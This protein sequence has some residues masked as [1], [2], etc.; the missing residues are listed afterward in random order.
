VPAL[1]APPPEFLAAADLLAARAPDSAWRREARPEQLPP[2]GDWFVWLV[3]AGRGWGKTWLGAR[4]LAEQAQANPG[5]YAVIGRSE[6]DTREICVE[7]RSGLLPALGLRLGS[8]EYSRATGQ[9]RLANG[10]V[11]YSMS[12]ES[13]ERTRGPNLSGVWTDELAAWRFLAQ[14]WT[15][16]LLPAVRIGNPKVVVTTTP[17]PVPL[18]REFLSRDDGSVVV[19]RGTTF[20]NAANLSPQALAEFRRFEGSRIGR[21][22]LLGELLD[23]VEGALWNREAI[24]PLRITKIARAQLVRVVVAVDPAVTSGERSDETGIIVAG[25]DGAGQGYVLDDLTCRLPPD[26]WAKRV[27]YAASKWKADKVIAEKNNGGDLVAS[28]LQSVDS[29]LPIK[30]V[31]ASAGKTLRAE[32]VAAYY[33]QHKIAH[34]G[35]FPELEDQMC[36]FVAGQSGSPDRLDALVWAF[37]ELTPGGGATAHAPVWGEQPGP[38]R[39]GCLR[40]GSI[41]GSM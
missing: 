29:S 34:V 1:T 33:E 6:Q 26:G 19:T 41:F 10:S 16:T 28:L 27:A 15:S 17:R 36:T 23:D 4:W 35:A 21:Q 2:D 38:S 14:T 9:I 12:A 20:E 31:S 37:T 18:L 7:G 39:W 13:P 30:L 40:P 25:L 3:M 11:I 32:P 5:D 22:E 8:R 24:E